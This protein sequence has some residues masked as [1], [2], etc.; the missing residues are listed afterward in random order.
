MKILLI[1]P[2]FYRFLGSHY[3]GM[4]LGLSY[5]A[6]YLKQYGYQVA[7]Y[8]ADFTMSDKYPTQ[9]ELFDYKDFKKN[10]EDTHNP[11]YREIEIAIKAYNPDLVM[12]TVISSTRE[13][14][15]RIA[16]MIDNL[17]IPLLVGGPH[18]T[19]NSGAYN[20]EYLGDYLDDY[21]LIPARDCYLHDKKYMDFGYII[22]GVG[23]NKDCIFCA[24]RKL[25]N[26]KI[27]FRRIV[28]IA[29]EIIEA[30]NNQNVK[31]FYFVDD[32]FTMSK[33]RTLQL[34]E[35]L[36]D[37]GHYDY[38]ELTYTCDT[39]L[40]KLDRAR[41]NALIV[42]GCKRLKVG[43]ES[44]SDKIL[45]SINKGLN[46]KQICEKIKMIKDYRI[47]LTVYLMIGFPDE[48]DN[49]VQATIDLAK[50]IEADYYSLSVVTPYP[51][52]KLWDIYKGNN[53][54]LH[55]QNRQLIMNGDISNRML[56]RFLN[57]NI[58]YGK[59]DR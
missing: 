59:G 27:K 2:P 49:D 46:T 25:C 41:L 53:G 55:H 8:N 47:D 23:C 38:S 14:T 48:T 30:Q 22:S 39:R 18:I 54:Y 5:I 50:W 44:G 28:T 43:I 9:E 11:I 31:H 17:H 10:I 13:V 37:L 36:A 33:K 29:E 7:I 21:E 16:W 42:S 45:N 26:K 3:N 32:T 20:R 34:C 58:D 24:A 15:R 57:I 4:H 52:T 40:D 6:S 19:L 51:G 35:M 56:D 1:N 12:M